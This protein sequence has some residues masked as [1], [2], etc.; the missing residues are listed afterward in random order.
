MTATAS[1]MRSHRRPEFF[2]TPYL[3]ATYNTN[4]KAQYTHNRFHKHERANPE[5]GPSA[6]ER[7]V[8]AVARWHVEHGARSCK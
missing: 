4:E 1:G 7:F 2:R 5:T 6:Q 8:A 3:I